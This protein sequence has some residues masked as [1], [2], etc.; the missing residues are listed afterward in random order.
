MFF[1]REN[2]RKLSGIEQVRALV[3]EQLPEA[4]EDTVQIVSAL[5][6]L[7]T[8]VAYA[9]RKFDAAEEQRTRAA[10]GD[11]DGLSSE[12]ARAIG[13]LLRKHMP[14]IATI[15]PQAY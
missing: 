5:A 6:G 2:K 7:L 14:E 3:R 15:N 12:G 9:D 13:E 4:D 8:C 11:V 1:R 10:L